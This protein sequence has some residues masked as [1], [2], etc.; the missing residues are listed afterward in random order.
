MRPLFKIGLLFLGMALATA[1]PLRAEARRPQKELAYSSGDQR[2][3]KAVRGKQKAAPK[4]NTERSTSPKKKSPKKKS[5]K[6]QQ[7]QRRP[8]EF[9]KYNAPGGATRGPMSASMFRNTPK[10][11][12]AIQRGGRTY[13]QQLVTQGDKTFMRR[14]SVPSSSDHHGGDHHGDHHGYHHHDHDQYY[15]HHHWHHHH[16][17]VYV[18]YWAYDPWFWGFYFA[19][20]P[21][22]WHYTW[23][24]VGAPWYVAWGWY[25][26]PYPY[27]VGP[28]YWVTDYTLARML[29]DEYERG[30]VEGQKSAGTPISEPVKEQ[31]RKQV[32]DTAKAFQADRSIDLGKA[33]GDPNYLF[34]V[35]APITAATADGQTCA[36]SGGDI[37]KPAGQNDPSVPVASMSVVTSKRESSEGGKVVNISYTDLQEMLNSFSAVV[38]DGLNELQNQQTPPTSPK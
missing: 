33:L 10:P 5:A 22:P 1:S 19:P 20:F 24:W 6:Q 3:K 32:D 30:Y 18:H 17:W 9:P 13:K 12:A 25:Y 11:P 15:H 34:I 23:V 4:R 29:A 36:L 37:V 7:Q 38:D 16:Y 31:V 14:T 21:A 8:G 27:Y 35:D 26:E 2:P 28:S